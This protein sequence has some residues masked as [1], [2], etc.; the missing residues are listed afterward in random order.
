MK[1]F[2]QFCLEFHLIGSKSED[3]PVYEIPLK[4]KD[5][6][7]DAQADLILNYDK[8]QHELN[9]EELSRLVKAGRKIMT[10]KYST[11][12][13]YSETYYE[14]DPNNTTAAQTLADA[15]RVSSSPTNDLEREISEGTYNVFMIFTQQGKYE[16]KFVDPQI[17]DEIKRFVQQHELSTVSEGYWANINAVKKR[18][19]RGGKGSSKGSKK[20]KAAKKAGKKLESGK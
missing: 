2:K 17:I 6:L 7:E 10:L 20:Y 14:L 8:H 12:L 11:D 13:E 9:H 16:L 19:K 1:T 3:A 5:H 4:L 18:K 15:L